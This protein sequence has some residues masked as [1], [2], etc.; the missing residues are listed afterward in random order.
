MQRQEREESAR[1]SG[2]VFRVGVQKPAPQE[3]IRNS[4]S[5]CEHQGT[6]FCPHKGTIKKTCS[7]FSVDPAIYAG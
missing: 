4:C 3:M 7:S 6:S 2:R 1:M 5:A